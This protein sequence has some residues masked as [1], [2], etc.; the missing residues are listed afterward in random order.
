M[1]H[2][3][4]AKVVFFMYVSHPGKHEH[5]ICVAAFS[6]RQ[7]LHFFQR[8]KLYIPPGL[9]SSETER[10]AMCRKPVYTPS[11]QNFSHIPDAPCMEYLST[12]LILGRCANSSTMVRIWVFI[13][14]AGKLPQLYQRTGP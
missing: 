2:C 14:V 5:L 1:C 10:P 4:Y 11:F 12:K 9:L 6:P 8:K 3:K 7:H 13:P